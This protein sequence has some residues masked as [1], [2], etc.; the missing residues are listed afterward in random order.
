MFTDPT[1]GLMIHVWAL[2]ECGLPSCVNS[3]NRTFLMWFLPA[4]PAY[5]L[6]LLWKHF[7]LLSHQITWPVK[8]IPLTWKAFP[9]PAVLLI[10]LPDPSIL[11]TLP[12]FTWPTLPPTAQNIS[13]PGGAA[14]FSSC[15]APSSMTQ[16][17]HSSVACRVH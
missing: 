1:W 8:L 12:L 15:L 16:A 2:V 5:S 17:C 11:S 3:G 9:D 6:D 14:R 4:F 7:L 10:L 13:L